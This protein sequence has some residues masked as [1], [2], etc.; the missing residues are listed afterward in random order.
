MGYERGVDSIGDI[1][2]VVERLN[3]GHLLCAPILTIEEMVNHPHMRLRGAVHL[4]EN[5]QNILNSVL[6]L[7]DDQLAA[8]PLKEARDFLFQLVVM[9]VYYEDLFRD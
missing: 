5:H 1:D 4:G 2:K 6:G 9:P 8:N 7:K 3:E